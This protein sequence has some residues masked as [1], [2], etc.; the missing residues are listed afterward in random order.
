MIFSKKV[1]LRKKSVSER[2][3]VYQRQVFF[4]RFVNLEKEFPKAS[5]NLKDRA[6]KGAEELECKK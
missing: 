1:V 6:K 2:G 4:E 5:Q 3:K